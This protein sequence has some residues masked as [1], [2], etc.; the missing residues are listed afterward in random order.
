MM[1][2]KISNEVDDFSELFFP[3]CSAIG[4]NVLARGTVCA[5]GANL[6]TSLEA[7]QLQVVQ[8]LADYYYDISNSLPTA[9]YNVWFTCSFHSLRKN[10]FDSRWHLR[11]RVSAGKS[12]HVESKRQK[13][14]RLYC[15][16]GPRL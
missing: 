9:Q 10:V 11:P 7:E 16:V 5:P 4:N 2:Q 12:S 14:R 3:F 1:K 13:S 15:A 6:M 8:I